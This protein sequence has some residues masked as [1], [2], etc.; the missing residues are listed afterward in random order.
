MEEQKCP[1]CGDEL[2]IDSIP[3]NFSEI[4]DKSCIHITNCCGGALR[5]IP[6]RTQRIEIYEGT[7]K[8]DDWA[9]PIKQRKKKK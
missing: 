9:N 2:D 1:L 3:L 4:Y 7:R 8:E 5:I 6:V